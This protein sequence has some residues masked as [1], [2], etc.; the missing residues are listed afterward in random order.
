MSVHASRAVVVGGGVVGV[1]CADELQRAGLTVTLVDRGPIGGACSHGNCGYVCPSHVLPHAG[2]GVI[3]RLL[4]TLLQRDSPLAIRFR[5]DPALWSWLFRFALRCR[6]TAM[7]EAG[8]ALSALLESSR[9]LYGDLL[10]KGEL[11]AD[12]Q[13]Q[14]LLFVFR[15]PREMEHYAHTDE[16]L[17]REFDMPA[18]RYSGEELLTLEPALK[19]GLAGGWYYPR[20][21]HLRPDRLLESWQQRLQRLGVAIRPHTEAMGLARQGGRVVGVETRQGTLSADVVVIA[22]GAW[23]PLWQR[24]LGC[25][26][27]IQPGKGYS[28]TMPRP[29]RCPRIPLIFE[30]DRVAI[31]PFS[32]G[33][34]IG[35]TMEFAG[36]DATLN[37]RR[38]DLLRRSARWYLHEPEAEPVHEEW[39]GWRP[40]VPDGKPII[41]RAGKLDNVYLATGH[42]ML[43]LSLA[44]GTARLIRELVTGAVPHVDATPYRVSR[45]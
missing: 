30:E 33:Y 39:W 43:G 13:Q 10:G 16:L 8:R 37:R 20:D 5:L 9:T 31:T 41:G 22:L 17:R 44:T 21:A 18:R 27:P 29:S 34:R 14:G 25:K 1:A 38:L 24:Q 32:D 3:G 42:G 6:H 15:T 19:P 45:F 7:M 40:M 26:L 12:W 28:I 11:Q 23:S 2:P 35:S 4:G 36:Y